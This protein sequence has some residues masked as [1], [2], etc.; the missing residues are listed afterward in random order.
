MWLDVVSRR[1]WRLLFLLTRRSE[2]GF[3]GGVT[4]RGP[5]FSHDRRTKSPG[6]S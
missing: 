1:K 2:G 4:G 6:Y 3:Q 5:H